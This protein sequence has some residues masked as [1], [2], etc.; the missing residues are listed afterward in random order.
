MV[1]QRNPVQPCG[2]C[3]TRRYVHGHDLFPCPRPLHQGSSARGSR[4][5]SPKTWRAPEWPCQ[6]W[7]MLIGENDDRGFASRRHGFG[8][9]GD[10]VEFFDFWGV[11]NSKAARKTAQRKQKLGDVHPNQTN[12]GLNF[13]L[14]SRQRNTR[15][16]EKKRKFNS[17]NFRRDKTRISDHVG[18][19]CFTTTPHFLGS[20]NIPKRWF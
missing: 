9:N 4:S 8:D 18:C 2:S 6:K 10:W 16:R 12:I 15:F 14:G 13:D 3:S 7:R 19:A 11:S 20:R 5:R 1:L 17:L